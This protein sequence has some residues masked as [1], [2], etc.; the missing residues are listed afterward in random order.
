ME[1]ESRL[2]SMKSNYELKHNLRK[3][4]WKVKKGKLWSKIEDQEAEKSKKTQVTFNL[5]LC[6]YEQI[7]IMVFTLILI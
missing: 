5:S 3:V 2:P 7:E 4:I 6:T 1:S